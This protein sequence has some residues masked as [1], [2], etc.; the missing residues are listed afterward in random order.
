[1]NKILVEKNSNKEIYLTEEENT[2]YI[3]EENAHLKVYHFVV[4]KSSDVEI[5]LKG[6]HAKV[7]YY[8]STINHHNN[9]FNIKIHHE[10]SNTESNVVNHGVNTKDNRLDFRVDGI[11]PKQASNC[12]CNQDNK[13]INLETGKSSIEPNLIIDNYDSIANHA[14]YIGNFKEDILFYLNSRGISKDNATKMLIKGFLIHDDVKL[15]SI[16]DFLKQ[17]D[18][19]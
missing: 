15:E 8:F 10:E 13:I 11:I 3:L 6:E 18:K 9:H 1:M 7:E 12:L 5:Y 17:I 2:C 4:D 19:L 16:E 14:A